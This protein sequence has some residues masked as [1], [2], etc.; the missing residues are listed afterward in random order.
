MNAVIAAFA[1]HQAADMAV[2]RLISAGC[3]RTTLSVV[4]RGRGIHKGGLA[5]YGNGDGVSFLGPLG[6][7]WGGLWGFS[8]EGFF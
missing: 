7:F 6:A 5:S 3:D 8:L 2:R 4:G 1:H